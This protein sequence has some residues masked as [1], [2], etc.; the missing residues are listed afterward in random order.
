MDPDP[1]VTDGPPGLTGPAAA[2][3]PA[4]PVVYLP[5]T[6]A[7]DG[8]VADVRM[9][10]L[11]DQRVALIAYTALDRLA[12]CCGEDQP[13]A[14]VETRRLGDLHA[15]KPFDVKLLDVDLPQELR[16]RFREPA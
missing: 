9:L 13:W 6:L 16:E 2:G 15:T 7:E 14:L 12:S 8:S 1:T 4:P 11:A 3:L 10:R 5:V